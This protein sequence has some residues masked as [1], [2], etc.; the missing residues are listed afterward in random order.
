MVSNSLFSG[1]ALTVGG[2]DDPLLPKLIQAINHADEIEITVSFIQ[3][4]GINL[5]LPALLDA[6]KN[7]ASI[8]ILTSNY[9]TITHPQALRQL[10]LLKERGAQTKIFT[11]H[12]GKSFHMKSYIFVKTQQDKI[13]EGCAYVGSNNISRTALTD[14]HEWCLR[15]D[16]RLPLEQEPSEQESPEQEVSLTATDPGGQKYRELVYIRQQFGQIFEH[17]QSINLTDSW[18][19]DYAKFYARLQQTKLQ[20]VTPDFT[21]E[22]LEPITPNPVQELAL[23]ALHQSRL[24]GF[25]RGLVVLATGMGKTWLAAFDAKQLNA[26]KVLFVAHREEILLQ[27]EK[28]FIQLV[29][30]V[31]T[32]LYNAK[33]KDLS[34][35]Y[36]FA[37]VQTLGKKAHLARF[38]PEHFDYVVIDEFHHASAQTYKNLLSYFQPEFLL[39]LTATPERSD[40]SDILSL[41]DN[42]LVFERNLVQGID[43]NILVPFHYQGVYDEFVDYQEIPWRNGKF[44]PYQLD[45]AFASRKRAAHIFKQW[46]QYK[47]SRTLAFCVSQKHADYM[48]RWFAQQGVKAVAVYANSKV[49]RNQALSQLAHGDIEV[50]FSV[51]LFNEG[52]DL[53]SID[54]ILMLRPTE[55][56]ILFLQQLGRGLRRSEATGKEQLNVVD[57]IGNH[58]SF[59]NKPATLLNANGVKAIVK[60]IQ[61]GVA[62]AAGCYVNYQLELVDFWQKLAKKQRNHVDDDYLELQHS[63]GHR[64]TAT[65]FFQ[66]GFDIV[67]PRK[68]YGSWFG[69]VAKM[70]Q[71]SDTSLLANCVE[72]H[73]DFL[74]QAIECTAMSK[75]FKAVLLEAFLALDGFSQP[76]TTTAL[77]ERSW[78][79]LNRRPDLKNAELPEKTKP[80]TAQSAAWHSYWKGNPI[81]A[82]CN[83]SKGDKQAWFVVEDG[84]FKANFAVTND[85]KD[86]LHGLMQELV[87][88]RL[89]QYIAR[90]QQ[91]TAKP[92]VQVI[93][94]PAHNDNLIALPFY[95]ELK[96]ACGH[97]KTGF[98]DEVETR[99]LNMDLGNLDPNVHF[100][101]P[102]SGNSMN[103]GKYPVKDGDLLLLEWI[104]PN[105]AGSISDQTLV[106]EQQ[107]VTGADQYLLRVV[108]KQ[109]DASYRL[110]AN[111][112]DYDDIVATD[113]M[114]TLARFKQVLQ[115]D[116]FE[117]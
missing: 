50:V 82:F 64:P 90:K 14:G 27:A 15:H 26:K 63:Q 91:K 44:D 66:Q 79:V 85:D 70:E 13:I 49:R 71:R 60:A 55:S 99:Q 58:H 96:I 9:L 104:T 3:P 4:S 81:K 16:Y 72:Q 30:N 95:P 6:L 103:G 93:A 36:L 28:T 42:N 37:S 88:L 17:V 105:N 101:A 10:M 8:K 117:Q 111:N 38:D 112:P 100:I 52:T 25:K 115:E 33:Q 84:L 110:Q 51:D 56:K 20:L 76:P 5:L 57:F 12:A 34:A 24:Q 80:L 54:T 65:E 43:D 73:G 86:T 7:N 47:Q 107:E 19:S 46:Q 78:A 102:A 89:A 53:P 1:Y 18:I 116:M 94:E 69:L 32:G 41:C 75:C 23:N 2:K 114:S 21:P 68:L 11:C 92:P 22:Q 77:A 40:Q 35:D 97:F 67:K 113:E 31:S 59:L 98:S 45:H 74:L 87:D 48:A 83:H 108:R 39:G 109:A 61:G 62:L 106:V 29:D